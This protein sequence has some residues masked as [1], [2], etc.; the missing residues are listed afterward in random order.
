MAPVFVRQVQSSHMDHVNETNLVSVEVPSFA[1]KEEL[2][3]WLSE[4]EADGF[5]PMFPLPLKD[6]GVAIVGRR[7][8][9]VP[10]Q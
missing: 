1:T 8:R 7:A 4:L 6:G 10:L 5:T 9:K 2:D 3:K